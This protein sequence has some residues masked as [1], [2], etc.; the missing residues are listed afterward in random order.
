MF[1]EALVTPAR[2]ESVLM[3]LRAMRKSSCTSEDLRV[4]LQPPSIS[5]NTAAAAAAIKA[6]IDLGLCESSGTRSAA[7]VQLAPTVAGRRPV[8]EVVIEALDERVLGSDEVEPYLRTFYSYMLS[9]DEKAVTLS[10]AGRWAEW[11]NRDVHSDKLTTNPFNKTKCR[12]LF[13]WFEYLGLG[14]SDSDGVFHCNP[15]ERVRRKL[16]GVFGGKSRLSD[17]EFMTRLAAHCPEL[18]CGEVFVAVD[19]DKSRGRRCTLG[20]SH[21]LVDLH[22]AGIL[23]LSAST[24]SE[25]YSIARASPPLDQK[26]LLGERLDSVKYLGGR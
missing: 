22:L 20:L 11:F 1:T 9:L 4:L 7:T 18:D 8:R 13:R 10:D 17:S 19:K 14:W 6:S 3:T 5:E 24:D 12:G 26:T 15:F 21:A 25:G 2:V 23:E 16:N